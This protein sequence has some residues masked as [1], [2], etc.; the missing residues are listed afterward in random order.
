[1]ITI[2]IENKSLPTSRQLAIAVR[3]LCE[4][5]TDAVIEDP[6][7]H[8]V[9]PGYFTVPFA[10]LGMLLVHRPGSEGSLVSLTRGIDGVVLASEDPIIE[11]IV[12]VVNA[13][14]GSSY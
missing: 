8:A 7:T 5:W 14:R 12:A 1:M 10:Q 13:S 11:E 2:K 4:Q 3:V 9:Y 6:E